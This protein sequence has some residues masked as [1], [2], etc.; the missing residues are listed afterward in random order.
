MD[1]TQFAEDTF[2]GINTLGYNSKLKS[3]ILYPKVVNENE[4]NLTFVHLRPFFCVCIFPK[5][6]G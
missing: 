6:N 5:D 4:M 3:N 1:V 2:V